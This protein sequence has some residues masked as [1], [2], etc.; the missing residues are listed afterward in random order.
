MKTSLTLFVIITLIS[1]TFLFS[2]EG[3]ESPNIVEI[4]YGT[5]FGNC[6]GY[7]I[8]EI[9]FKD[10]ILQ[11]TLTPHRNKELEPSKC[12]LDYTGFPELSAKV[13]LDRFEKLEVTIGC[14]D[15]KEE[16]AEWVHIITSDGFNKKVTYSFRQEPG[17]V[18][19]YIDELRRYY[20]KLADCD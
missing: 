13:D 20:E 3:Q 16:G 18:V 8:Q 11:K 5:S 12:Y 19:P 14:P 2:Q 4:R 1:N 6:S 10:G 9:S 17:P 7:C 15:C